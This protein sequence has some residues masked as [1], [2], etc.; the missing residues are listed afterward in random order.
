M[1]PTDPADR[2]PRDRLRPQLGLT[3]ATLLCVASVIGSGIFLTPGTIA[4]RL[5]HAGLILA[6]WLAGGVLSLLGALA[7]AELGAMYPHAGGD[8][9]YLREAFSPFAGFATGWVSFFAIFTGTVA[10]LAAGVGEALGAFVP[11]GEGGKLAVA[12]AVTFA[13][14]WLNVVGVRGSAYVNNAGALLKLFALG[15]LVLV[16]PLSGLGDWTRLAPFAPGA[17]GVAPSEFGL[18]LSPVLF[19]YLGWNATVFVASEIHDPQRNVPRSLFLGLALCIAIYLAV[20]AVYLYA[21]PLDALQGAGNAGEATARTLFGPVSGTLLSLFVLGSIA[22]TLNATILVGPRIAYAMAL[23][24]RF[25]RG[26]DGVHERYRTPHVAIWLQAGVAA[27]LL[28]VLRSFPSVLDFT[29]FAIVLA[30]IADTLALYALRR[31]RPE[32]PRPYRAFGYPWLP[33]VYLVANAA[34]AFAMLRGNPRETLICLA[35]IASAV[36]FWFAFARRS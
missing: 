36:P 28:L 20:N 33:A 5:P 27:L 13:A 12:L 29:T 26:V 15:A 8:Y 1:E 6:V 7:N 14:S 21:L 18:A 3:D 25:F 34:V 23:D 17:G 4:E 24:E 31:S 35:V 2:H 9:V 30:T 19:S 22:A 32:A 11:L 10:T 16:A